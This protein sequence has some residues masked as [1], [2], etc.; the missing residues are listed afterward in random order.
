[1]LT[2]I[3]P[4]SSPVT[5]A[6]TPSNPG[7]SPGDWLGAA[8]GL[9]S[10]LATVALAVLIYRLQRRDTTNDAALAAQ[11]AAEHQADEE[12]K[13]IA[14]ENEERERE[15]R[16]SRR[17]R[18]REDY[19]LAS[20]ALLMLEKAFRKPTRNDAHIGRLLAEADMEEFHV[21]QAEEML[22]RV[23][24]NVVGLKESLMILSSIANT[25][26][27]NYI[28]KDAVIKGKIQTE[29]ALRELHGPSDEA[30]IAEQVFRGIIQREVAFTGLKA[31]AAARAAIEREWGT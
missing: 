26:R 16:A 1:M 27:Y 8:I 6:P 2:L 14:K 29:E 4:I 23:G 9:A 28:D 3:Y 25:F 7:I 10:L 12:R 21:V 5:P 30:I 13:R 22:D 17:E 11:R 15:L 20:E 24:A 31:I 18:H 19:N